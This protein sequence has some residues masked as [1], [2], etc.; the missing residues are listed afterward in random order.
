MKKE[1]KN[2]KAVKEDVRN[3]QQLTL[4]IALPE[5]ETGPKPND[6]D[7]LAVE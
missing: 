2:T 7:Y 5:G 1:K 4:S 3:P 6:I